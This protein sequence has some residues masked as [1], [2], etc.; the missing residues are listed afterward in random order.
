MSIAHAMLGEFE[1][2]AKTTRK[3]LERIPQDKLMWKPHEKSFA[4]SNIA[5]HVAMLPAYGSSGRS[6]AVADT[7]SEQTQ[8]GPDV[9]HEI[10]QRLGDDTEEQH[11]GTGQQRHDEDLGL[12]T[13][14][15]RL[16]TLAVELRRSSGEHRH[17]TSGQRPVAAC[18]AA[19]RLAPGPRGRPPL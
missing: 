11:P 3:F 1:H 9:V 5:L 14:H 19:R 2:E 15:E 17:P 7:G 13:L 10:E 4:L 6:A 12:C 18:L 16:R 8:R